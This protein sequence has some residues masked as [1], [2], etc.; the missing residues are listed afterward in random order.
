MDD[1][2]AEKKSQ[3][4]EDENRVQRR[5]QV[6]ERRQLEARNRA[7]SVGV[8]ASRGLFQ[9]RSER[10]RSFEILAVAVISTENE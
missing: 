6:H 4:E 1:A 8:C 3:R 10:E 7:P 5:H 2:L 9:C